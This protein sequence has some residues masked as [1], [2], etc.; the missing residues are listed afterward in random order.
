MKIPFAADLKLTA[1][2]QSN[3][4]VIVCGAGAALLLRDLVDS[5]R[6]LGHQFVS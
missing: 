5:L 1:Q 2:Q 3:T 4:V 6:R